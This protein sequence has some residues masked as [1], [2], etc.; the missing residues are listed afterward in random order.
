MALYG[1]IWRYMA[2]YGVIWRYMVLYGVAWCSMVSR[3]GVWRCVCFVCVFVFFGANHINRLRSI[4]RLLRSGGR[5][6]RF[7]MRSFTPTSNGSA[8][9][10][11]R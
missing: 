6:T 7:D 2:L 5:T 11:A 3:G 9:A 8:G 1:V 10:H 4:K